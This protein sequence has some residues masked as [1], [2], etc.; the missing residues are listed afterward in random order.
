[1]ARPAATRDMTQGSC[2]KHLLLFTLPLLVGSLLQQLYSLVDNWVV[3]NFI[4]DAALGAL[5][6]SYPVMTMY[7]A[8]FIGMANG[9]TVIIA[10]FF[11]AGE[12][13]RVRDVV[14]TLYTA[15][16]VSILPMTALFVLMTKPLLLLMNADTV[17]LDDAVLYQVIISAGI[18]GSLGYNINAAILQGLGNSRTTLFF[19]G[20]SSVLNIVLDLLFVLVFHWGVAGT[21]IATVI[22]QLASWLAGLFYINRHYPELAIHPF[23]RRFDKE[24]FRKIMGIGI[25]QG[26]QMVLVSIGV[27]LLYSDVNIYGPSFCSGYNIAVKVENLSFLPIQALGVATTTFAGQN[28]GAERLDRVKKSA[29]ISLL[30]GYVWTI[31]IT[32]L[33]VHLRYEISAIFS[34]VPETI[35]ASALYMRCVLT[36]HF[37]F[38]TMF[39]LNAVMRGAGESMVPMLISG[40]G[41]IV[42]RT[43]VVK[44]LNAHYGAELM[45]YGLTVGYLVS[46]LLAAAYILSGRWQ[47]R[48]S[49][50]KKT[51]QNT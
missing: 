11:G 8:F 28:M 16:T 1:M 17:G 41:N 12:K 46:A 30:M 48:G 21:A 32:S 37:L 38:T 4:S 49:L 19:L 44:L 47:R 45:Y 35:E 25:P 22:A 40:F 10:Q 15:F 33:A 7:T 43:V 3:G 29:W 31:A 42:V 18:I 39:C 2:A 20:I 23:N 51:P 36:Y 5:G 26:L 14:D 50:V 6:M 34:Q 13:H 27:M 24:L 9:G